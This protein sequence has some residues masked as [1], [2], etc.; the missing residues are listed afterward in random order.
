MAGVYQQEEASRWNLTGLRS[1]GGTVGADV[2]LA[3]PCCPWGG[4]AGGGA[5]MSG[6]G[7]SLNSS[8]L[9]EVQTPATPTRQ[10]RSNCEKT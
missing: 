3:Q 10:S 9:S 6:P 7:V 5:G 4:T 8:H 2:G 1:S